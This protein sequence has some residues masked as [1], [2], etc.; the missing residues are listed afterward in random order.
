MAACPRYRRLAAGLLRTA[1][2]AIVAL[3]VAG[4]P[5]ADAAAVGEAAG[6]RCGMVER[7]PAARDLPRAPRVMLGDGGDKL[8]RE[9]FSGGHTV[10]ESDNFALKW[11]SAAVSEAEVEF[12]LEVLEE[13]WGRYVGELGHTPPPG[14]ETFRINAY[15]GGLAT[16]PAID[17]SGGYAWVD[18]EG[19]VYLVVSED[20][21]EGANGSST[22][23][24]VLSH[25]LYHD[26]QLGLDVFHQPSGYWYWEATAD[27]ASQQIFPDL[28]DA[29]GFVG[30]FA[31][32]PDL[33]VY[34]MG[35][36]FG[37]ELAGVHQYGA[38]I[39]PRHLTDRF[40][41]AT[42]VPNSWEEAGGS[43]DPLDMLDRHLPEGDI[44]A[45][46]AEFAPR[47]ARLDFNR[48]ELI[49]PW[50]DA[51]HAAYPDD[52][53]AMRVPATGTDGWLSPPAGREPRSFGA[54][55][56]ELARPASGAIDL[57][58][59]VDATGSAGTP[60][61]V[62]AVAVLQTTEGL[63]YVPVELAG[64]AGRVHLPMLTTAYLVVSATADGRSFDETF[65][66]RIQVSQAESAEPDAG[67]EPDAGADFHGD[68]EGGCGCASGGGPGAGGSAALLVAAV[69]LGLRRR[70]SGSR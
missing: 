44:A 52:R 27:W 64:G 41:L 14:T 12:A 50:V 54:N 26:V 18:D 47:M 69:L 22:L 23:R 68:D 55:V 36:P 33:P 39:F 16:D 70:R 29:Y 62:Q 20:L 63:E 17:F 46:W 35:D 32:R 60:A 5:A 3:A 8:T 65:G 51:Y 40:G 61:A 10:A 15:V 4:L 1:P 53:Y 6:P 48:G 9:P 59:E 13:A 38:S 24:H 21:F 58:V 25:E 45:A 28:V 56:I 57:E 67:P 2:P 11:T 34:Y 66:Y 37:E 31:M 7:L 49:E 30:A 42:L 19:Y 43:D